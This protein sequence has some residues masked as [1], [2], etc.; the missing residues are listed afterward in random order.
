M[1]PAENWKVRL[2]FYEGFLF[3]C[4]G[5]ITTH[6]GFIFLHGGFIFL[7]GWLLFLDESAMTP[8]WIR[9]TKKRIRHK[10]NKSA[11]YFMADSYNLV[12]HSLKHLAYSACSTSAPWHEYESVIPKNEY[13]TC[14]HESASD[15]RR[16]FRFNGAW[17]L[18]IAAGFIFWWTKSSLF[19][20]G[21]LSCLVVS[22]VVWCD[23]V[24]PC[25]QWA[26]VFLLLLLCCKALSSF[27]VCALTHKP[28]PLHFFHHDLSIS[29]LSLQGSHN[30]HAARHRLHRYREHNSPYRQVTRLPCFS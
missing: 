19:T 16:G 14:F 2:R 29:Y 13:T 17:L 10:L 24:L 6:G 27:V 23:R 8:K 30:G 11:S 21:V 12:A 7:C 3:M 18:E 28:F 25:L 20:C 5:F 22:C 4:G 26:L 9:H 1:N 15:L